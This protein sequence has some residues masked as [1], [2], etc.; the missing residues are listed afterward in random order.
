MPKRG[1][2]RRVQ[3]I[4]YQRDSFSDYQYDSFIR[5]STELLTGQFYQTISR[6]D[7]LDYQKEV[8]SDY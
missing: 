1:C 6:T 5:L 7:L 8:L 4:L 2:L 3:E